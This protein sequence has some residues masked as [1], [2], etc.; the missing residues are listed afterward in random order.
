MKKKSVCLLVVALLLC[1]HVVFLASADITPMASPVFVAKTASLSTAMKSVMTCTT[2][3]TCNQIYVSAVT[4]QRKS[5]SSWVN[6]G[7]LPCPTTVATNA[8][9]FATSKDYS[10]YC[11]RGN[12][13]RVVITFNAD[14]VTASATS[15][16]S[17]YQ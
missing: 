8:S 13:Y 12:T 11:T 16:S 5:G 6:A 9:S 1:T 3:V 14:G 2:S 17:T 15:G 4:L 7:P 10:S